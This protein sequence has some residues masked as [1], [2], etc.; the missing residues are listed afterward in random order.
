MPNAGM[1]IVKE[2][3]DEGKS[4]LNIKGRGSLEQMIRMCR[5]GKAQL[6]IHP[7]L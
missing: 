2:Y 1:E 5:R 7:G 4:G 3:S 6:Q